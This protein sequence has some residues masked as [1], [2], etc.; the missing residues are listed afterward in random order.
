M[1]E[2]GKADAMP[3]G[4]RPRALIDQVP[5]SRA[6][7][8]A[9]ALVMTMT[10]TMALLLVPAPAQ[11]QELLSG[12]DAAVTQF[13]GVGQAPEGT[14]RP[15]VDGAVL[16]LLGLSTSDDPLDGALRDAPRQLLARTA[17]DVGQ[18]FSVVFDSGQPANIY[19]AA[20]SAYG[21]YR[22]TGDGGW[23][24]GMW[25]P[26]GGPGTIWK[27][28]AERGYRAENFADIGFLDQPNGG[29]A[30]GDLAYDPQHDQLFVSDL[31][32]GLIHRLDLRD[33]SLLESF[34][35]GTD[36]RTYFR[37]A[38]TGE[39]MRLEPVLHD[40]TSAPR[41]D[42]CTVDLDGVAESRPFYSA[43]ECWNYADFRR[44]VWGLGTATDEISGQTRLYY[45][46]WGGAALG[47]DEWADGGEDAATSIWSV[48]LTEGGW[49]DATDIRR[50]IVLPAPDGGT[51]P[52]HEAAPVTDIAFTADGHMIVAERGV[53]APYFEE[54]EFTQIVE[55]GQARV[56][57][58]SRQDGG[59]WQIDGRY[60]AGYPVREH[61]PEI[62]ANAAGGVAAA[63]GS[64]VIWLTVDA[65]CSQDAPCPAAGDDE[66]ADRIG[67]L[68]AV[69]PDALSEMDTVDEAGRLD[70][71]LLFSVRGA[72]RIPG[73]MGAMALHPGE[74]TPRRIA[75]RPTRPEEPAREPDDVPQEEEDAELPDPE[76]LATDLAVAKSASGECRPGED[77]DFQVTVVNEGNHAFTG[78]LV[79]TDTLGSAGVSLV[80]SEPEE[81]SCHAANA[82]VFCRH[83]DLILLPGDTSE[84]E[85]TLRVPEAHRQP[86]LENCAAITWFGRA[87]R[88]RI[89]AVQAE[90]GQRGFDAGPADGAMGPRTAGAIADARSRLGL[91]PGGDIAADLVEALFGEGTWVAGDANPDNDR[92]CAT[93]V[94]DVPAPPP[95][96]V[97][98]PR[99]HDPDISY[100]HER[101]GSAQH[102]P[103]TSGPSP[104]HQRAF[105]QFHMQYRSSQHDGIRSDFVPAHDSVMSRFHQRYDSQA[106]DI[107]TSG[108]LRYHT[109]RESGQRFRTPGY[110]DG[111]TSRAPRIHEGWTSRWR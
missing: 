56:L 42:D 108:P 17:R 29:A 27:L 1:D 103:V 78:P 40:P 48:A 37:D 101:R 92:D 5:P 39:M 96:T 71:A 38:A 20:T 55:P 7:S 99:R 28:N 98:Q 35:H 43:P 54:R 58:L 57:R 24:P 46:V 44:R 22:G 23:A 60:E 79:I 52:P 100:F 95:A 33:G 63:P 97:H 68:Q 51:E 80:S 45:A 81:W 102:N 94:V 64:N 86:R 34:D 87:G 16:R 4:S 62:R 73:D 12:G 14:P 8:G 72:G 53:P 31:E 36:G 67:G 93:A 106:H 66:T 19:L 47:S 3:P 109:V 65:L 10:M 105:S 26:D 30:L 74:T 83:D 21:L 85:L 84:L 88:D 91:A 61:E 18:V 49:F 69:A 89:R 15:S 110:H 41:F 9:T 77:C 25:G 76:E 111:V 82:H 50:E 11:A 70:R 75:E 59:A 6:L 107:E 2:Q 104:I 32:S 90:L 13:S